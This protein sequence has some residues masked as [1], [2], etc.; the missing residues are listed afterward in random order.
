M[1]V[2][3]QLHDPAILFP[4]ENAAGT[5][6][7]GGSVGSGVGL[8][9]VAKT[10]KNLPCACR[11]PNPGRPARSLTTILTELPRIINMYYVYL[12]HRVQNGPGV[13]PASY[14]MDTRVSFPGGK[15]ARVST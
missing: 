9:A 2:S 12:H 5:H 3:G 11:E 13:H 14:P 1:K 8:E 4:G 7:I 10:K 15:A 6:W